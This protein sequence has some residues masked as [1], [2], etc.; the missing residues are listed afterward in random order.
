M[1]AI[2]EMIFIVYYWYVVDVF[3]IT[4]LYFI[5][6]VSVSTIADMDISRD[7]FISSVVPNA[8]SINVF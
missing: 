8:F 4:Y 1:A 3:Q 5:C 7:A 2:H 6:F